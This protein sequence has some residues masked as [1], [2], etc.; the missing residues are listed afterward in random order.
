MQ[1]IAAC[2]LLVL[3]GAGVYL[4][5]K[6]RGHAPL[7]GSV[8]AQAQQS[9][10]R[11]LSRTPAVAGGWLLLVEADKKRALVL[12]GVQGQTIAQWDAPG[13]VEDST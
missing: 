6:R 8:L 10:L 7:F 12:V 3:L 4:G 5:Q 11:V 9:R 2:L 1:I 13:E